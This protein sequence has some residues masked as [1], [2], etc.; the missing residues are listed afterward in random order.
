MLSS[1][2]NIGIVEICLLQGILF[3]L[4]WFFDSYFATLITA[5]LVPMF[6]VILLAALIAEL[7]DRSNVPKWYFKLMALSIV[8]LLLIGAFYFN[9]NDGFFDWMEGMF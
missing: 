3:T 1:L 4:M 2:K 6:S 8:I 7:L 5:I 9:A